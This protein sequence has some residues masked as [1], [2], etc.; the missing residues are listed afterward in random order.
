MPDRQEFDILSITTTVDSE[1]VARELAGALV[2]ARL[3]ACVQVDA[4]VA[5]YYHWEEL[6]HAPE[7]RLTIKTAPAR[8]DEVLSFLE[9]EHPYELPQLTWQC[10]HASPAY[11]AW[12][13]AQVE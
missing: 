10:L 12:V 8:L 4:V 2:K 9:A 5:S 7:W 13:A 1:A 3:A 11:G 6:E